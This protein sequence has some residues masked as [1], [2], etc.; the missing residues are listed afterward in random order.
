MHI[1]EL[2]ICVVFLLNNA[3][4]LVYEL[5]CERESFVL[6][7]EPVEKITRTSSSIQSFNSPG[8]LVPCPFLQGMGFE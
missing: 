1:I 6:N 3:E 5:R 4:M 8:Y 7:K 2:G